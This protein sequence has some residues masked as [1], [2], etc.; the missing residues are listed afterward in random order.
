MDGERFDR[1]ARLAGATHSRRGVF[2]LLASAF[3][4]ALLG[5]TP[6]RIDSVG[7][8]EAAAAGLGPELDY[9][10][11][12]DSNAAGHGLMPTTPERDGSVC[13][14]DGRDCCEA[15]GFNC[16][17]RSSS[18]YP[19]KVAAELRKLYRGVNVHHIACS[20][21]TTRH[22]N[23]QVLRVFAK[24]RTLPPDRP[25]L[26]S[27][28]IGANDFPWT[29]P[30]RAAQLLL[31]NSDA[32]FR[33]EIARILEGT[34]EN[35]LRELRALLTAPQVKV[36]LTE[37]HNPFNARSIFFPAFQPRMG[38][39]ADYVV[40]ALI[41]TYNEVIREIEA[42]PRLRGRLML[43][44]GIREDF[45]AHRSPFPTCGHVSPSIAQTWIQHRDDTQSN[46]FPSKL[47]RNDYVAPGASPTR[48]RGDCM[49]PNQKGAQGYANR[50]LAAARRLGFDGGPIP[51]FTASPRATV[52]GTR[53][54]ISWG[55]S[56]A[57]T[58]VVEYGPT[59]AYGERVAVA[60]PVTEHR[61][62]LIGLQ[63]TTTYH[64]RVA[65]ANEAGTATSEDR[66]FTTTC[67][68]GQALCEGACVDI[69][70]NPAHC[71]GCDRDCANS[72][73]RG[74]SCVGCMA[75]GLR[76]SSPGDCCS[77]V[78]EAEDAVPGE[79]ARLTCAPS[80]CARGFK[81]CGAV[82][83]PVA[84]CCTSADCTGGK[85]CPG[86]GQACACPSGRIDCGGTCINPQ[87]DEANC[88]S[89][90][91]VCETGRTCC[92]GDC[93]D[94]RTDPAHCGGCAR[95]CVNGTCQN[96]A[97]DCTIAGA[98][99]EVNGDCCSGICEAPPGQRLRCA[100]SPCPRGEKL[101]NQRCI[102]LANCCASGE[103][104]GGKT[105]QNGACACPADKHDCGDGT[106][107]DC[108]TN[109]HCTAG[110][111]CQGG[112]CACPAG[113]AFC[114]GAC[115]DTGTDPAHCGDCGRDCANSDCQGGH[116]LGCAAATLPCSTDGECCSGS[117]E[118]VDPER[119]ELGRACAPSP[120]ARGFKPCGQA[121]IPVAACCTNADCAGGKT[122]QGGNCACPSGRHDCGDGICRAC[123]TDEHCPAG[124]P[125]QA[126]TCACPV[127]R[128]TDCGGDCVDTSSDPA[129]CG[130]CDRP[131]TCGGSQPGFCD[132]GRCVC[133]NPLAAGAVEGESAPDAAHRPVIAGRGRRRGQQGSDRRRTPRRGSDDRA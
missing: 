75:A 77:G 120:C 58:S 102:P 24:L 105:C 49:H 127:D 92:A 15:D 104:D 8:G 12:G 47:K 99:C 116:C 66:T 76:C 95:D 93:V 31:I 57:A 2:R 122:C 56:V 94:T 5:G 43:A 130:G 48:W 60:D 38:G 88:G 26:V 96:G 14:W 106:C 109:A 52:V 74:G 9:F 53:A 81:Q 107:R 86:P 33:A 123:C 98:L 132:L 50:V 40:D 19:F 124:R 67:P 111:T 78:C 54:T 69:L 23:G 29:D 119:R 103:C 100:A 129:H 89:C 85:V 44:T 46:S 20:G 125:C 115:V 32:A 83:I 79:P 16:C 34:R 133:G 42:A 7:G 39:R 10:A 35:L 27:L 82:C 70:A 73:C 17:R 114:D 30:D 18:S 21:A 51:Q 55:T 84:R 121:C 11:L 61:V 72:D 3:A 59:T 101:C 6:G 87:T 110:R 90:G 117:C 71:G 108:C 45:K 131:C 128:P 91:H 62:Q 36:V 1:L 113:R 80:P 118:L 112:I 37:L 97:C 63:P 13:Q 68:A 126:G 25:V 4:G 22:L 65:S 64:Y 28:T 41:G